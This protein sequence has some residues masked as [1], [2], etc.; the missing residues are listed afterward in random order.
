MNGEKTN[1]QSTRKYVPT[2]RFLTKQPHVFED[3]RTD[4]MTGYART[5]VQPSPNSRA[6]LVLMTVA[7]IAYYDAQI[8]PVTPPFLSTTVS[9]KQPVRCMYPAR[10][11]ENSDRT[12]PHLLCS[13]SLLVVCKKGQQALRSK[14]RE[15]LV[16]QNAS[17]LGGDPYLQK[18]LRSSSGTVSHQIASRPR[19]SSSRPETSGGQ[20]K[21]RTTRNRDQWGSCTEES[22]RKAGRTSS[23]RVSHKTTKQRTIPEGLA[24]AAKRYPKGR[25]RHSAKDQVRHPAKERRRTL[26][27][28][29]S[30][31]PGKSGQS[32]GK[33]PGQTLDKRPGQAPGKETRSGTRR[34]TRSNSRKKDR[35]APGTKTRSVIRQKTRSDTRKK[36]KSGTWH[37]DQFSHP[38][39][40]QVIHPAKIPDQT[41][42]RR[43]GQPHRGMRGEGGRGRES[44][45]VYCSAV[46]TLD[47]VI[48]TD[49]ALGHL[50][51]I[52]GR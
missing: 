11:S 42:S 34:K 23:H 9:Q 37:K 26:D 10:T 52:T 17:R 3:D 41:N 27:K 28:R 31:E 19:W 25:V 36:T 18:V 38:G 39:K 51:R 4:V 1:K 32:S 33:R 13:G 6:R 12:F 29:P 47:R 24:K 49:S 30:L 16:T 40:E 15:L 7:A 48:V 43:P 35:Q 5:E 14:H 8:P 50:A 45:A 44:T 21:I 20:E 46:R 2:V 22:L